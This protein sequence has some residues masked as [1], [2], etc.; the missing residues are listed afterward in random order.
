MPTLPVS[1]FYAE[2][3]L[4]EGSENSELPGQGPESNKCTPQATVSQPSRGLRVT[5]AFL[6]GAGH[7]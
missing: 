3:I 6:N 7:L 2:S 5:V 4:T 1:A